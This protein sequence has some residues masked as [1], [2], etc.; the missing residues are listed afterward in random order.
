MSF[1]RLVGMN[2]RICTA[3]QYVGTTNVT[4]SWLV[5]LGSIAM[6]KPSLIILC[7]R[8]HGNSEFPLSVLEWPLASW[9]Y[10]PVFCSI[11]SDA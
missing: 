11:T 2:N 10:S 7:W 3:V 5:S 8:F 9:K 4:L 1:L 6:F